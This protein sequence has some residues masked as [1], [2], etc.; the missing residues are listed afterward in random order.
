M[1][2]SNKEQ[3]LERT[4]QEGVQK[5]NFRSRAFIYCPRNGYDFAF[6]VTCTFRTMGPCSVVAEEPVKDY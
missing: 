4:A 5:R 3:G 2:E 6:E 1:T